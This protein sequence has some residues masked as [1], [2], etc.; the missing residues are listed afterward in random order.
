MLPKGS[1]GTW[2]MDVGRTRFRDVY[3]ALVATD[4]L[5]NLW[6]VPMTDIL[7]DIHAVLNAA[8]VRTTS[9]LD[10]TGQESNIIPVIE[11]LTKPNTDRTVAINSRVNKMTPYPAKRKSPKLCPDS[12]LSSNHEGPCCEDFSVK[13]VEPTPSI[14]R[15][16]DTA[17]YLL[18]N[19]PNTAPYGYST[20]S[21]KLGDYIG[22]FC[23]EC[24]DGPYLCWQVSCQ[25][26]THAKCEL[27][28]HEHLK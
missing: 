19:I 16:P 7:T 18:G 20:S 2:I 1:S 24:C 8:Q 28:A 13:V 12:N 22:W 6:M 3:G 10:A 17:N 21:S 14:T 9:Q 23:S 15:A 11:A 25:S 26:C 4:P 27:C 5:G